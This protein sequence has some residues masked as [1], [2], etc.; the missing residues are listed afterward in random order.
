MAQEKK[1]RS[2]PKRNPHDSKQPPHDSDLEAIRGAKQR[3]L[4]EHAAE[5]AEIKA[6]QETGKESTDL[7]ASAE[8]A[9]TSAHPFGHAV[10][11]ATGYVDAITGN[12]ADAL[13][14]ADVEAGAFAAS[15]MEKETGS[16]DS[17]GSDGTQGPAGPS[18][19]S[20]MEAASEELG[21]A[22]GQWVF[23]KLEIPVRRRS[24][25]AE[26]Q[27]FFEF[28]RRFSGYPGPQ[29]AMTSASGE[30]A[31]GTADTG[32]TPHAGGTTVPAEGETLQSEPI[33]DDMSNLENAANAPPPGERQEN[34]GHHENL[35]NLVKAEDPEYPENL[36]NTP[37]ETSL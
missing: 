30:H 10:N 17:P 18:D 29:G 6:T 20:D 26:A 3:H 23:P 1:R 33:R 12:D 35:E 7:E 37:I 25:L 32:G 34:Q 15:R 2:R 5:T 13:T 14:A 28:T 27:A 4:T 31:E 36:K 24:G 16:H 11:P 21:A 22:P 8:L 9:P 19:T